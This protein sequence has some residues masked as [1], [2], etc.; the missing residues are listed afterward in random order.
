M[1]G[2][3]STSLIKDRLEHLLVGVFKGKRGWI[4]GGAL[5]FAYGTYTG[6]TSGRI[7]NDEAWFLQ[8]LHRMAQGEVLYRDIFFGVTPLSAYFSAPWVKVLGVELFV[9]KGLMAVCFA[10]AGLLLLGIL[11]QLG[12][13]K[14]AQGLVL[15]AYCAYTPSWLPAAGTPYTPIAYILILLTWSLFLKW[16]SGRQET[17]EDGFL[18]RRSRWIMLGVLDGLTFAAKQNLGVYLLVGLA[19]GM[20]VHTWS[21]SVKFR[22]RMLPL[23]YALTG[24]AAAAL[25]AL[26]PTALS[27]GFERFLEYGFLNRAS[28]IESAR[29]TYAMQ[30]G[31]LWDML[32]SLGSWRNLLYAHW[33]TQYLFAPLA[34]IALLLAW[35]GTESETS[36]LTLKVMILFGVSLAGT[37]PRV[38]LAHILPALPATL[39]AM[40]WGLSR[41]EISLKPS[42]KR[43]AY[44]LC[45]TWLSLGMLAL[46]VRPLRWVARGTHAWSSLRHF[47]GVLLPESELRTYA[48]FAHATQSAERVESLFFLTPWA[49]TLYLLSEWDNPT[50]YDYPLVTAFG[51][52]GQDQVVQMIQ[53]GDIEWVCMSPLG[54]RPLAPQILEEFVLDKMRRGRETPFCTL[55]RTPGSEAP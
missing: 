33:Q 49:S 26:T 47:R 20:I 28:Y 48:R 27:G 12:L 46:L 10:A 13:G 32:G 51:F 38:D 54:K 35:I 22:E 29:I 36:R 16:T 21:I 7:G 37:F 17:R 25:I 53:N 6:L 8:V 55:Y 39:I 40:A 18:D 41:Y 15:L 52:D 14:A 3:E 9:V 19:L 44:A 11:Q 34:V 45:A 23:V 5:L 31:R 50:P 1:I 43:P 24:F 30:L 2:T 42:L 4:L